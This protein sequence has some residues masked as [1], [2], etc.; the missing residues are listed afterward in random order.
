[1]QTNFDVLADLPASS[2][3]RTG[4]D[5]VA[6]HLGRGKVVQSTGAIDAPGA[7]L[8]APA[9]L[10]R[11]RDVTQALAATDGVAGVT[12]LLS[13]DGDGVVP[14]G[15]R[16]S[17]QLASMA[18][19]FGGDGA[20]SGANSG[21]EALL[22]ASVSDGLSTAAEYLGLLGAAFPDAAAG[23]AFRS[24]TH[25]LDAARDEID[26]ART[27]ALV[28]GQ[29]RSL[30]SALASPAAAGGA[31]GGST[32]LVGDYL[33]E[34][35]VAHPSITT[36]PHFAAARAAA[37]GLERKPSITAALEASAAL[38]ALATE[39][40]ERG[41]DTRLFPESLSGTTEV[42]ERRARIEATFDAL[43]HDL[44]ALAA[45]FA[46]RRDDVFVPLG[47][48]G[49]PGAV[50]RDAVDAFVAADRSMTRFYLTTV[51]DPYAQEAFA[52]IRRAQDVLAGS[53]PGFGPGAGGYL[54]GPSAEFA[55]VQAV[56]SVDFQ[57]VGIVTVIGILV[58]LVLLLRAV[59]APL[60]L[61][62]T[63]LLSCATAIGVS[64]WYFQSV[65]GQAG[66]SFYLPLLVFVLLVALGSDY[67]IFLMSRVR[68]ESEHRPIRDGIRVASGRTGA[69]ITSAGLILAGTFG[70]MAT[71]PLTVLF[72]VGVAVAIGVLIDT[73]IVRSILVPAITMLAGDRAWWPFGRH[74][75]GT[76]VGS[77][78]GGAG[79]R[80]G[81]A[82][83]VAASRRT[84]AIAVALVVAV[85]LVVAGL[86]SWSMADPGATV[87]RVTGAVVDLDEGA[88]STGPD[89]TTAQL[90]LGADLARQLVTGAG[91]ETLRWVAVGS[92]EADDGLRA[93]RY[94]A[95]LTIP[96]DFSARVA[97]ILAGGAATP[98]KANLRLE[99]DDGSGYTPT[100]VARSITTAIA[101]STTRSVTARYVADVLLSVGSAR[102]RLAAASGGAQALASQSTAVSS[103]ADD[104][105][106]VAG[107]EVV[108][109]EALA[110]GT[111]AA[112]DG[113][114][115]LAS[116]IGSLASGTRRL[117]SGASS[118]GT[119]ARAAAEGGAVLARGADSLADGLHELS[120]RTA[121]LPGEVSTLDAGAASLADLSAQVADGTVGLAATLDDLA[122]RTHGLGGQAR[123]LDDDASAVATDADR[124]VDS[125]R[126]SASDARDVA[127]AAHDLQSSIA[128]YTGS[129]TDLAAG[130]DASG[131][132]ASLCTQLAE[133]AAGGG[134]L[135]QGAS[136][137]AGGADGAA[138]DAG[139]VVTGA[140]DVRDGTAGVASGTGAFAS[141]APA[142]EYGIAGAAGAGDTVAAGASRAS[143]GTASLAAGTGALAGS[144]PIL[145]R[146]VSDAAKG[147]R[148]VADGADGLAAG[149]AKV[150]DGADAIT[151][152][153]DTA[154]RGASTLRDGTLTAAGGV[155]RLA[156]GLRDALDGA[157][158]VAA[159]ADGLAG[160]GR[161]LAGDS[162][163]LA[164]KLADDTGSTSVPVG[165]PDQVGAAVTEPVA[166]TT[167][168]LHAAGT[169]G[170]GLVPYFMA[171]ALWVGA[172][173]IYLVLPAVGVSGD[174]RRPLAGALAGLATGAVLAGVQVI[175][176]VAG[177]WLGVG[178]DVAQPAE[179]TAMAVIAALAAVGVTHALVA[180]WGMRG[181]CCALF[182]VAL[183]AVAAG[184]P[185]PIETA[186]SL[187]A[188]IHPLL[189]MT[190]AVEAFRTLIAAGGPPVAPAVAVQLAWGI[191]AVAVTLVVAAR[192]GGRLRARPVASPA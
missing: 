44:D 86:F 99:T 114:K 122:A 23:T 45:V 93:G 177:L 95:V 190:W 5:A 31:S 3:A 48:S 60:Y 105:S 155:S 96:P 85:P 79:V 126:A 53:A 18:D 39:V 111:S 1:M 167:E 175:A 36:Y 80:T 158:I 131:A 19:G 77:W 8:L 21:G 89:G 110:A 24:A 32:S 57:R 101:A 174:R 172:L 113:T 62:G 52:T 69:V 61:V 129:V 163:A 127:S 159:N 109:L 46:A 130:C 22:D 94:G 124:L 112:S 144:M 166:V 83:G 171:L 148:S 162:G 106:S 185:F 51:D 9:S 140:R 160:R 137:L 100:L 63:V 10:A 55:D 145:S 170:S 71:A 176:L 156:A 84:T 78:L 82:T 153:A 179:L 58:V 173:V 54:G 35:A 26:G 76:R 169:T 142:L 91:D 4:F 168:R 107:A 2:D 81:G 182:L 108:G 87:D 16:P 66:V 178:V 29:L 136:S 43:P 6:A 27:G 164:D 103:G 121:R 143:A 133:V 38:G 188:A 20:A 157:R 138:D 41:P 118:L 30:A 56:L 117:A 90:T 65:L 181:W 189:P 59:V 70:S 165:S 73:F 102:D 119:G 120:A 25:D 146:A 88:P 125:A 134:D 97:A 13:P 34:L 104:M 50:I 37:A 17:R 14:D 128:G 68:E 75:V 47:L 147:A 192:R 92:S 187:L 184:A 191:G 7:D 64:S 151:A 149:V 150:A 186:P 183:Q 135:R 28:S 33:R 180:T 115:Q 15:F 141:T 154:A 49:E 67:N 40:V 116:G 132:P 152:G 11:L 74:G 123:S 161:T 98:G 72:Q 42:R 139:G 12:G